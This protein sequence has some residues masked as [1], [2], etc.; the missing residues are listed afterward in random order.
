MKK[1][2]PSIK[3]QP[4]T[5][6]SFWDKFHYINKIKMVDKALS[7]NLWNRSVGM[8]KRANAIKQITKTNQGAY[9]YLKEKL[10]RF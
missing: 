6:L 10:T 3:V 9:D 1:I 5:F 4:I 8:E 2:D 7:E